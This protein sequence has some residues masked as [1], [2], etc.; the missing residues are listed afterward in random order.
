MREELAQAES[1]RHHHGTESRITLARARACKGCVCSCPEKVLSTFWQ[2][3]PDSCLSS[4]ACLPDCACLLLQ[5]RFTTERLGT[6]IA[7]GAIPGAPHLLTT[8]PMWG[9]LIGSDGRRIVR[10]CHPPPRDRCLSIAHVE[11]AP[12]LTTPT[13]HLAFV[14]KAVSGQPQMLSQMSAV[15]SGPGPGPGPGPGSAVLLPPRRSRG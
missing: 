14:D 8:M 7:E 5:P 9:A 4:T 11:A 1:G 13:D 12:M 6:S 3:N 10:S 2:G 15:E